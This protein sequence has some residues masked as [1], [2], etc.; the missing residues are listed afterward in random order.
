[1]LKL[2]ITRRLLSNKHVCVDVFSRGALHAFPQESVVL[3]LAI[4][5]FHTMF[6]MLLSAGWLHQSI[7]GK[8][9]C[10]WQVSAVDC[11]PPSLRL[12]L[13]HAPANGGV[14]YF[15]F[16]PVS[17]KLPLHCGSAH[18]SPSGA[19]GT[20]AQDLIVKSWATCFDEFWAAAESYIMRSESR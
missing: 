6:F 10:S 15:L 18:P 12:W 17:P 2:F 8:V 13:T 5:L 14:S 16:S 19:R 3:A 9:S 11:Q 7:P 20:P 4:S 1:M